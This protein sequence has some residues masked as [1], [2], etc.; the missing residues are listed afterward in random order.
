VKIAISP[1]YLT[2]Y[3][4]KWDEVKQQNSNQRCLLCGSTMMQT[5]LVT[6]TKGL[7]YVGYVCHEDKQVTWV[8]A[9]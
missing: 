9:D 8:R 4:V 1:I 7:N 6:D 5:E 3:M 2:Y